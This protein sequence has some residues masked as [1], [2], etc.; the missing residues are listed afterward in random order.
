WNAKLVLDG[1]NT[2]KQWPEWPAKMDGKIAIRGSLYGGS[3]QIRIPE[4][5][6]DGNVKQ[7]V[8]K[9]HGKASGNAAGQW[10]IPQFDLVFG[11]NTL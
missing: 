11:R 2:A 3:W 9:A 4:I 6:L 10:D 8:V 7:N 5:T 1:I